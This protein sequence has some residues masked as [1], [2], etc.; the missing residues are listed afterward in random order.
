VA[1]S[2]GQT[3]ANVISTVQTANPAIGTDAINNMCSGLAAGSIAPLGTPVL[4]GG[5]L[6]KC[7]TGFAAGGQLFSADA[8][9]A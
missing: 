2:T 9:P 1:Y 8:S 6:I 7:T 5:V 3:V 4:F